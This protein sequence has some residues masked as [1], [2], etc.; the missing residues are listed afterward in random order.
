[1]ERGHVTC[2]DSESSAPTVAGSLALEFLA[3]CFPS[4]TSTDT[5]RY[6]LDGISMA[7]RTGYVNMGA[8]M[9]MLDVTIA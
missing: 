9:S 3:T 2:E 7:W 4:F 8:G 1:M 5:S 6:T